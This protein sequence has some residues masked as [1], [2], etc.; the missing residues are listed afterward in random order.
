MSKQAYIEKR[1]NTSSREIIEQVNNILA[2]YEAQGYDLSLR[3]LFYQMVS[4]DLL[5]NTQKEYKRLGDIV[6]NARLAGLVDWDM[7]KDRGRATVTNSHFDSPAEIL[8]IAARQFAIDKWQDQSYHV[9]VMVE[10][11]ALEGV[12]VPVC[13]DL[14]IPFT[15]NKG[16]SSASALRERGRILGRLARKNGKR[17]IVLYMGDHDPSGLDMT[18]D[19]Q[20][21]LSTFA[22]TKIHVERLALNY[23]QIQTLKPPPNTTK[24][25]DTRAAAY[26]AKYK[27]SWELDAVEPAALARIVTEAVMKYRDADKWQNAVMA[28]KRMKAE[29][30]E[31]AESYTDGE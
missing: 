10:K 1:F 14:D 18:R 2:E 19:V 27:A 6:N 30:Q 3:Q 16:Y 31:L 15:A 11:Q 22:E 24:E 26:A 5:P 23:P 28:E 17:I 9:E 21:R 8:N 20:D 7:I 13:E 25:N 4:R 29:L 12:L